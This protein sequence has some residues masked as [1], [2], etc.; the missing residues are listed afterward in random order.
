MKERLEKAV[1]AA[2]EAGHAILAIYRKDFTVDFKE[3]E[4]PLT[5]ADRK[6]D[7][8]IKSMLGDDLPIISEES[9][10]LPYKVR[11]NWKQCWLVDP[12]DGTK[13]FIKKNDEFTVNIAL[14]DNGLPVLG[15]VYL[16]VFR[17]L[18]IGAKDIGSYL[19][20]I[21]EFDSDLV[22]EK[23]LENGKKFEDV[24][25]PGTYTIVA[26][27]SHMSEETESFIED[28]RKKHGDV[29]LISKGS[30][31]KLCLVAEGEAHVYPRI[32]PTMEWDTGAAHAV[33]K[34]AG[35]EV[36]DFYS[37]KELTYNKENLLNPFFIVKR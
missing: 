29:E 12:L 23:L 5:E 1:Q 30:S 15:V 11:K 20:T 32:A 31:I 7:Q 2:I 17:Q 37:R 16:P 4:S 26:S 35:C 21:D 25:L 14:I 10:A 27:R 6:A 9:Q 18:Y 28:C 24:S 19:I 33:A 3:D 22:L 8:I 34:Y 36:L 13:E